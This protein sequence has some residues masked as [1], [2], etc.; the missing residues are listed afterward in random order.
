M[1][2]QLFFAIT[3][4][5]LGALLGS[6]AAAV[7]DASQCEDHAANCVGRCANPGAGTNENKMHGALRPAGEHVFDSRA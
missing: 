5:G 6:P 1:A 7:T 4:L 3:L 2:R